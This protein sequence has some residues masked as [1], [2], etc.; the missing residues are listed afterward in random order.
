MLKIK[1]IAVGKIKEKFYTDA[2]NEYIKRLGAFCSISVTEIPEYKCSDNPSSAEIQTVMKKEGEKIL[3]AVPEGAYI[4]PM[5][6]E[7][8]QLSSAELAQKIEEIS[9]SGTNT[10]CFVIGG[11]FGLDDA[12]KEKGKIRLSMSKMTFPHM[13][14]RVMLI[15]QIY[16]ALSINKG[17]KYH[18]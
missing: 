5:C 7:G 12:V 3:D 8:K 11:S 6:I 10:I 4:I 17:T 9:I 14:A 15:E 13:L 16:R 2:C 1:I 18:K